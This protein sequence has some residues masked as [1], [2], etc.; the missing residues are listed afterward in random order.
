MIAAKDI[1]HLPRVW[2]ETLR[3]LDGAGAPIVP[4]LDEHGEPDGELFWHRAE[5]KDETGTSHPAWILLEH[6]PSDEPGRPSELFVL[7]AGKWRVL[8]CMSDRMWARFG[9]RFRYRL[10]KPCPKDGY[11]ERQF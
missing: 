9:E 7:V 11:R 1:R 2:R 5:A 8:R 10:K 3:R 6:P 4:E